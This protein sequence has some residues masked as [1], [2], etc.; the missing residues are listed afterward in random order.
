VTS[1]AEEG[2]IVR[3]VNIWSGGGD[4]PAAVR[5]ILSPDMLKWTDYATWDSD[6]WTCEWTIESHSFKEAVRCS[7][8]NRF[9]EIDP[10]RTRLEIR[11]ELQI[12]MKKVKV[13]PGFLAST[14]GRTVEQFMVKQI[15][16]NLTTVSGALA[17]HLERRYGNAG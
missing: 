14:L 11:G 17:K 12:D 5:S 1:R 4:I 6:R 3:L 10:D 13:V 7:G 2:P 9:I 8:T 16:T 15:T